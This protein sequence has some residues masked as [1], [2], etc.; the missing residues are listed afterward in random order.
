MVGQDSATLIAKRRFAALPRWVCVTKPGPTCKAESCSALLSRSVGLMNSQRPDPASEAAKVSDWR[1][2]TDAGP[3]HTAA[4]QT[5]QRFPQEDAGR[6]PA[7]DDL[8]AFRSTPFHHL[9]RCAFPGALCLPF[10]GNPRIKQVCSRRGCLPIGPIGEARRFRFSLYHIRLLPL[11]L[12]DASACV[13]A[14]LAGTCVCT[15][16]RHCPSLCG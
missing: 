5:L 11:K 4:K 9:H 6:S 10:I 3:A 16:S 14:L 2:S 7:D 12:V 1:F 15:S 13:F 8:E